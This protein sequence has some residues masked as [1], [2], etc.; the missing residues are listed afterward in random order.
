MSERPPTPESLEQVVERLV[1]AL[2]IRE[3]MDPQDILSDMITFAPH[4]DNEF[5]NQEYFEE[6]AEKMY[7]PVGR[8]VTYACQKFEARSKEE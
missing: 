4:P 5:A 7:C 8:L 1:L 6:L 2:A 3:G